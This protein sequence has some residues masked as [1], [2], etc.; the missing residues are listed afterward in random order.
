MTKRL[1]LWIY[2]SMVIFIIFSSSFLYAAA[3][4]ITFNPSKTE[5]ILVVDIENNP[6]NLADLKTVKDA[7][8]SYATSIF[9][10]IPTN[11]AGS[12][13]FR[14]KHLNYDIYIDDNQ[15][16][17][18]SPTSS[19]YYPD[20]P[21]VTWVELPLDADTTKVELRFTLGY[22]TTVCSI[23][24]LRISSSGDFIKNVLSK[25]LFPF[26][27]SCIFLALSLVLIIADFPLNWHADYNHEL[28]YL[29]F[30]ALAA[31]VFSL[32]E[33]HVLQLFVADT[34]LFH[35][36][37]YMS[38]LM[39]P[40]PMIL[41]AGEIY[42]FKNKYTVLFLTCCSVA[43]FIA[44]VVLNWYDIA[45][46]NNMLYLIIANILIAV[47]ILGYAL[48][49]SSLCKKGI[50]STFRRIGM[51][52]VVLCGMG[53][54]V[55]YY[56]YQSQDPAFFLRLG[57][58]VFVCCFG[59]SSLHQTITHI[60]NAARAELIE[61]L[62]YTDGLTGLSNRT[63]YEEHLERLKSS[64]ND[65]GIVMLD[66]NNLKTVNDTLGHKFGDQ[67]LVAGAD[68]IEK[69]FPLADEHCYRIGGDEFVIIVENAKAAVNCAEGC[70]KL[71]ELCNQYNL[72]ED[73][74]FTLTI[75]SGFAVYK[76][77]LYTVEEACA[78]ADERMYQTK[79]RMKGII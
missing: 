12:L 11:H 15:V 9:F 40:A 69:A 47:A 63:A 36:L 22:D 14:A 42:E 50:D 64:R 76:K 39:L 25:R 26:V 10:I 17:S 27:L 16:Y 70:K 48:V 18:L 41:Y 44:L 55:R 21:G 38:L 54:I 73:K 35:L 37:A 8:T 5:E 71:L 46:Y 29:G 13:C 74:K 61:K 58:F 45:D 24:N 33:T 19:N 62:A 1:S 79:K 31:S 72:A 30:I 4:P 78:A 28:L 3:Q 56:I 34:Q 68:L 20:S 32:V 51:W 2:Y 53:D 49:R 7:S 60:K 52:A 77:A 43:V 65:V 57:L 6:V 67:L 75:A 59:I 66:V 23:D